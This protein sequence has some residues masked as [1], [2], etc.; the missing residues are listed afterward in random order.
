MYMSESALKVNTR[1]HVIA[2]IA[3]KEQVCLK[4]STETIGVFKY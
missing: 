1:L 2:V 3:H 4:V